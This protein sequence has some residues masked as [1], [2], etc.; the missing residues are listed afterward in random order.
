MDDARRAVTEPGNTAS[1]ARPKAAGQ[2]S[3]PTPRHPRSRGS[4]AHRHRSTEVNT[5][6]QRRR[7]LRYATVATLAVL[8]LAV[9]GLF[10]LLLRTQREL[11][12]ARDGLGA[13][14]Q[15]E[16][17]QATQAAAEAQ[18][19]T[20]QLQDLVYGRLPQPLR[21]LL[22]DTLIELESAPLHSIL[23]TQVGTAERPGYEYKLICRNDGPERFQPRYRI[24]LFNDAG[25]QTGSADLSDSADA[26]RL[27]TAGMAAGEGMSFS[28][29]VRLEFDDAP[30]YFM[31][32]SLAVDGQLPR[33]SR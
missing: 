30:R 14:T 8:A 10:A 1:N 5:R 20:A 24:L 15:A 7:Q 22:I 31:I 6:S 19:L 2:T 12:L 23:F 21:P 32:I 16:Q 28:G 33:L 3:G 17:R 27:D 9:A 13:A 26:I 25:I 4:R 11:S 29:Q 18:R